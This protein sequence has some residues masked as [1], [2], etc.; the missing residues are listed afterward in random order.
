MISEVSEYETQKM[1]HFMAVKAMVKTSKKNS[2]SIICVRRNKVQLLFQLTLTPLKMYKLISK[3]D[4]KYI[5][6]LLFQYEIPMVASNM[7]YEFFLR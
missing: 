7:I 2:R 5:H 3:I 6:I 1:K 4:N